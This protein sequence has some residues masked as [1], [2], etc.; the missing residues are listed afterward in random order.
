MD[1]QETV[2]QFAAELRELQ[3]AAKEKRS[4]LAVLDSELA[5][6][7]EY[8]R[9][10]LA[11]LDNELSAKKVRFAEES[12]VLKS[13]I[14]DLTGQREALL[15]QIRDLASNKEEIAD[16]QIVDKKA[17]LDQLTEQ[18][19]NVRGEVRFLENARDVLRAKF[20]ELL[21]K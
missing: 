17:S 5:S 10:T 12:F 2:D 9:K 7:T 16:Q 8:N 20:K 11:S 21:E 15:Q 18:Y 19:R 13:Q 6:K 3:A 14:Q 4:L 1:I